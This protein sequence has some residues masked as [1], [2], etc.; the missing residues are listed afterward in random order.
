LF[1]AVMG[2]F[3]LGF[4]KVGITSLREWGDVL[5]SCE[6]RFMRVLVSSVGKELG[7]NLAYIGDLA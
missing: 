2:C 1:W 5:C 4:W 6:A 3:W 7:S